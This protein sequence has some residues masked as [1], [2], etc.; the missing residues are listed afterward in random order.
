MMRW[1]GLSPTG[2]PAVSVKLV[3]RAGLAAAL[4]SGFR[5]VTEAERAQQIEQR[6]AGFLRRFS[7][8]FS[9]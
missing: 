6:K 1:Q 7:T 5:R 2:H 8:R 3:N 4:P 9:E